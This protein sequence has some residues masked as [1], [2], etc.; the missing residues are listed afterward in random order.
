MG[1]SGSGRVWQN[2]SGSGRV[3]G[4]QYKKLT[5]LAFGFVRVVKFRVRV[6]SGLAKMGIFGFGSGRVVQNLLGSGLVSGFRVPDLSL[7][8]TLCV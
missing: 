2:F 8:N 6:R 1:Y 5:F 3:S 7:I 4:F